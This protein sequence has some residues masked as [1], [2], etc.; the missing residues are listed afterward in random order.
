MLSN[1]GNH[2]RLTKL[3]GVVAGCCLLLL[4]V[5]VY[6]PALDGG[7]LLD[8]YE[9]LRP[10]LDLDKGLISWK[11][12]ISLSSA[13]PLG[14]PVAMATF[15]ANMATSGPDIYVFKVTNLIIHLVGAV[16]VFLLSRQ[17]L[18]ILKPTRGVTVI[19]WLALLV[20]AL[21]AL[22]PLSLSTTAYTIQR[23]TQLSAVFS[24]VGLLVYTVGRRRVEE[25]PGFGWTLMLSSLVVWM[26][27]AALSKENAL[28][29]PLLLLLVEFFFFRFSGHKETRK[30]LTLFFITVV[31]L[32]AMAILAFLIV[33]PEYVL[34]GYG[35]R[36]FSFTQRVL[37]EPRVLFNYLQNLLFP[38]GDSMG[39]FHDDFPLSNGPLSPP[40]TLLAIVGWLSIIG[41]ALLYHRRA[42]APL[43]FGPCFFLAGHLLESTIFPLELVFEH[44]NYLPAVGIFFSVVFGFVLLLERVGKF[45][46]L[47]G[48]MVTLPLLY[49][50][51]TYQRADTWSSWDKMLLSAERTHPNSPRLHSELAS[52]HALAGNLGTSLMHLERV[53]TLR[54]EAM[55][56]VALHRLVAYCI[57]KTAIPVE[58]YES[59]PARMS[60]SDADIYALNTLRGLNKLIREGACPQMDV[61]QLAR[62][63]ENWTTPRNAPKHHG[64]LWDLHYEIAQLLYW[65]G[66]RGEAI[67]HLD[68]AFALDT[69]RPEPLLTKIRYQIDM[70]QLSAAADTLAQLRSKF[71]NPQGLE[72]RLIRNYDP[73]FK[74]VEASI[75]EPLIGHKN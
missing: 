49:G 50:F 11:E 67:V 74:L 40:T 1:I 54:R 2:C 21:W 62:R 24:L 12:A 33:S 65:N 43:L 19:G 42:W 30:W 13:G 32:P 20:A 3:G 26:P 6:R 25:Q 5:L 56:A 71:P 55:P 69:G 31:G 28:L 48:L 53:G 63:I 51:A 73:F 75:K 66:S 35:G 23:M 7:F 52:L 72:G 9:N 27:L 58:A 14:R 44:R 22:A 38:R 60:N 15:V 34:G 59:I 10:L 64:R 45:I 70:E 46:P 41:A 37:T 68:A 39:L 61:F 36:S 16:L 29:L 4:T 57:S 17:W 18:A 47:V 8:D